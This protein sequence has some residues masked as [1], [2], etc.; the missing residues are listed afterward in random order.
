MSETPTNSPIDVLTVYEQPD[1]DEDAEDV[2]IGKVEI[3][4]DGYLRVIEADPTH[5]SFLHEVVGRV[6]GK[7][8]ILLRAQEPAGEQYMIGTLSIGRDDPAFVSAMA[9]HL[10]D[11]YGLRFG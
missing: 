5:G 9:S 3:Y 4:G 1:D 7:A 2:L 11:Y 6:N 8:E 10:R